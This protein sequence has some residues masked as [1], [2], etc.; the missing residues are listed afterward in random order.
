MKP[1]FVIGK[2]LFCFLLVLT[3]AG[4]TGFSPLPSAAADQPATSEQCPNAENLIQPDENAEKEIRDVLPQLI[5]ETY[6]DDSR[7]QNYEVKRI[8]S[9]K[10][11]ESSPYSGIAEQQCGKEVAGK[12][13]LVE[14]FFPEFLPS[15]SLS[16]GQVFVAKTN[17]GWKVWYRYH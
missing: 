10:D 15:A 8:L 4:T 7:Y 3:I 11:P 12:S 9:L 2:S 6:G 13:L 16:Q 17:E 5:Q 1:F 14:L